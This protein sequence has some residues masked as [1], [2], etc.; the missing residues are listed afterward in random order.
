LL[1]LAVGQLGYPA[2]ASASRALVTG[3]YLLAGSSADLALEGPATLV[4]T[5]RGG[6]SNFVRSFSP[7]QPSRVV[8][9][10][11]FRGDASSVLMASSAGRILLLGH[12]ETFGKGF[13]AGE[14]ER[15]Q[16][17]RLGGAL[18]NLTAGCL[19]APTLDGNVRGEEGIRNHTVVAAGGSLFAYDSF[20]CLV[21]TDFTSGRQRILPL[22]ATLDPL[23]HGWIEHLSPGGLL[24]V[25]GRLIAYRA[26]PLGGE[27]AGSIAVYDFDAGRELYRVPLPSAQPPVPSTFD[28][29]PDGTLVV[30]HPRS[31]TAT[32]ST[33]SSPA[34]R[35]L[36]TPACYVRRVRAG[37]VLIVAPG[38]SRHSLLEWTPIGEPA[39]HAIADLGKR[40][41]LELASPDMDEM[42]VAYALSGCYPR[43]FRATLAEPGAPPPLP[44][45]CPVLPLSARATLTTRSLRVALKCPL[46]CSGGFTAW[47]GTASQRRTGRGG[48][49]VGEEP[50][51]GGPATTD[52]MLAPNEV[53]TF[54]ILP[55]DAYD[56]HPSVK[57]LIRRLR[58]ARERLVLHCET[59]APG[60]EGITQ[61]RAA[62]L[63]VTYETSTVIDLPIVLGRAIAR[64]GYS[65]AS[66]DS[67]H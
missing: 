35:P 12:S 7:G 9:S 24:R 63:R 62:E 3:A 40:G 43:V 66:F 48:S 41:S 47:I 56:E 20:G 33:L 8:A 27:G 18:T 6:T 60:V 45:H 64:R 42:D 54:T 59:L 49:Y 37:R 14:E 55:T 52:Y 34:P 30:A 5:Q 1:L 15:L 26:N 39:P 50:Y 28:L 29:A 51:V 57:G 11:R 22:D 13:I 19:I 58:D 61:E 17:G 10:M 65:T 25:S 32:V 46:G 38:P 44:G 67:G 23:E 31:C 2:R 21:A 4:A 36:G 53:R 16:S